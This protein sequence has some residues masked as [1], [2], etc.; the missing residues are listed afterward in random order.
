VHKTMVK[1]ALAGVLFVVAIVVVC[2]NTRARGP[3]TLKT[4][5]RILM[6]SRP[7]CAAI[8]TKQVRVNEQPPFECP[9]CGHKSA[10][11]LVVCERCGAYVPMIKPVLEDNQCPYCGGHAFTPPRFN[12]LEP[13]PEGA[14]PGGGGR[15]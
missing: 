8:S 7:Q 2:V 10:C 9:K 1:A 11:L 5:E 12:P 13:P 4:V 6:C 15:P 3:K 14:Q